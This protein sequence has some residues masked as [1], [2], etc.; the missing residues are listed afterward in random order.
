M[1]G[2]A[3]AGLILLAG[4]LLQTAFFP[5]FAFFGARPD[6]VTLLVVLFGLLWGPRSGAALGFAGGMALDLL[7][8]Y[9]VGLG[10]LSRAVVG[11]LAGLAGERFFSENFLV[12]IL[13]VL[14]GTL[15]EQALFVLGAWIYGL[16]GPWNAGF[17]LAAAATAW[18]GALLA[19]PILPGILALTR[20]HGPVLEGQ[21]RLAREE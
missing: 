19:V 9:L 20:R 8:G 2:L 5:A 16:S 6:L 13:S 7:T 1:K 15:L 11:G 10:A 12:P 14:V 18:Y 21:T 17:L 4:L 3:Y